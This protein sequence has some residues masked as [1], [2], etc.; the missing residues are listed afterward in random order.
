MRRARRSHAYWLFDQ[1]VIQELSAS[2]TRGSRSWMDVANPGGPDSDD[3]D[4]EHYLKLAEAE[5][6]I[7]ARPGSESP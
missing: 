7:D 2:D 3:C 4:R 1:G 5:E 6:R